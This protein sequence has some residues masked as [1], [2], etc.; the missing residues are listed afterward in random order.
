MRPKATQREISLRLVVA[1][2][3]PDVECRRGQVARVVLNLLDNAIRHSPA[4]GTVT[5]RAAAHPG[6]VQ[7]LIDD[8][9]PGL[10]AAL[11]VA[12]FNTL[13]P[14][15]APGRSGRRGLAIAKAIVDAHGGALWAPVLPRG[16]S[17]RFYLP[18][19]AKLGA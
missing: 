12:P 18:T 16:T 14:A 1:A 11:R 9:G 8:N 19:S 15:T 4:G 7:V 6:G 3:L 10:P 2:A 5:V 17:V 13:R